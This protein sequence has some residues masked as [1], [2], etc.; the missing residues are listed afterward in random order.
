VAFSAGVG[1]DCCQRSPPAPP[2][3]GESAADPAARGGDGAAATTGP[4]DATQ[5][6]T[7]SSTASHRRRRDVGTRR[8]L[9]VITSVRPARVKVTT[10]IPGPRTTPTPGAAGRR[11][12]PARCRPGGPGRGLGRD[13]STAGGADP[14]VRRPREDAGP[15]VHGSHHDGGRKRRGANGTAAWRDGPG[16]VTRPAGNATGGE[17]GRQ[18]TRSAGNATSGES[19]RDG[20]TPA[21]VGCRTRRSGRITLPVGGGDEP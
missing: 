4:T 11:R 12:T 5:T 7:T 2:V 19:V 17:P 6:A 13:L 1:V 9:V 14:T 20:R 10:R 8:A 21:A 15:A 18:G 16:A 3:A